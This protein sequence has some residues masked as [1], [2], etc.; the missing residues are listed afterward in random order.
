MLA[1]TSSKSGSMQA[2]VKHGILQGDE[3]MVTDGAPLRNLSGWTADGRELIFSRDNKE[4]GTDIYA[5]AVEGDHKLRPLVVA[6]FDQDVA[7]LSPDGKWLAYVSD[8]SG[9]SEVFVQAMN[10]PNTRAQIS[11]EGGLFPRWARSGN[12]LFFLAKDG[13]MSV[14]FAPGNAL[15]PGKPVKLFQDK[16]AWSGYDVAADGRFVVAV[17]ADDK[18]TGSQLNVILN[19][20]EELKQAQPK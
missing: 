10:D 16:K 11:S 3:T 1:Y 18:V 15:N 9:Q 2:Y 8:E 4:T 5:V 12:E 19:W 14:K 13:L 6:P 17:E 7:S 20:F